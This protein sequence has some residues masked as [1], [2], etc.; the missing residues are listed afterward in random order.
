M[1]SF[2]SII[3]LAIVVAICALG[4]YHR[5][6][7]DNLLQ[8]LGMS[9]LVL[10]CISR[11]RWIW[12]FGVDDPSWT[13]L[14]ASIALYAIGTLVKVTISHGRA[15]GWSFIAKF[16]EKLQ[17]RKTGAGDFDSKPHHWWAP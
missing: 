13:G 10:F 4:L 14:H 15:Q 9:G 2:I 7:N 11:I 12:A 1:L 5:A 6:F 16:D 17:A 8:C 3:S